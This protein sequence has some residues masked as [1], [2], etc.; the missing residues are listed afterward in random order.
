VL[1]LNDLKEEGERRSKVTLQISDASTKRFSRAACW[2]SG[3]KEKERW[4]LKRP[5]PDGNGSE[6]QGHMSRLGVPM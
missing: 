2:G 3:G 4:S 1:G 5:C 6:L